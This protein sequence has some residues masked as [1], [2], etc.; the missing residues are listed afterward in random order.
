VHLGDEHERAAFI[1]ELVKAV[2]PVLDRYGKSHGDRYRVAFATHP[3][4]EEDK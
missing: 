1:R 3:D 4:P 2:K